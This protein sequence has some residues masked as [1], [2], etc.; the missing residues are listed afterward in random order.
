MAET[1][2]VLVAAYQDLDKATKDFDALAAPSPNSEVRS[3]RAFG[4]LKLTLHPKSYDWEFIPV[5]GESFTDSGSDSCHG[6]PDAPR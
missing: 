4:V 6:S 5:P 3:D 1:T 2:D